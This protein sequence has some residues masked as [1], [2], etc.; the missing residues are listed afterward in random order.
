VVDDSAPQNLIDD[1]G[2]FLSTAPAP[3]ERVAAERAVLEACAGL[4]EGW[5]DW[6]AK[7]A[8]SWD[9]ECFRVLGKAELARR[10]V[11]S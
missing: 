10:A 2:A 3:T 9:V 4:D 6:L 5:L 8:K 7:G 1:T 11:K